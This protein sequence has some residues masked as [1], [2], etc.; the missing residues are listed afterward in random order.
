MD[1]ETMNDPGKIID[2]AS[3]KAAPA[4]EWMARVMR[5][6]RGGPLPTVANALVI[7]RHDPALAGLVAYDAFA[8]RHLLMRAAPAAD[9][10]APLLPGPYPRP[11]GGEDVAMIQA[12]LQRLWSGRFARPTTDDAILTT[13]ALNPFHP[14]VDWLNGLRW[15]GVARLDNWIC[16][17]FDADKTDYHKAIA[18][19]F[20]I[21]GVRRVRNPGCKF[22]HMPIF[23]GA[24]GIGK[25]TLLRELFGPDWFS[26]SIPS[27]LA[28][29][30]AAIALKGVWGM[31]F[32]EIEHLIRAEIETLKAF[33]SRQMDHY[34]P[35]HG[36]FFVDVPR[37]GVLMGTTNADE[38]LRD[39]SGNRRIW[40]VKCRS[41]DVE[42]IMTNRDQ[43]WAEAARR[44]KM[45]E[46]IWFDDEVVRETAMLIQTERMSED[47]WLAPVEDWLLGR[48][49]ARVMD[50]LSSA[51]GLEKAKQTKREEMRI[52]AIMR[53]IG[54]QRRTVRREGKLLKLWLSAETSIMEERRSRGS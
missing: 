24:Q 11:W 51:I 9:E 30:D 20:L 32:A 47:L 49:E 48:T 25:S 44:E 53:Q 8:S 12:Y 35:V 28:N 38:Y 1:D 10:G 19:K 6:Q 4:L 26:D 21:A 34:R 15:D 42:W 54:W 33:L 3:R 37:Q 18:S 13:A 40:P 41:A 2:M 14:V 7:F 29:R 22:D 39:V 45:G 31:E 17:A 23:E 50:V 36:R 5:D 43:L 27:D 16:N 52:G 46:S